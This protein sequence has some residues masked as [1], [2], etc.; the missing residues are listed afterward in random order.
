MEKSPVRKRNTRGEGDRLRRELVSA[1]RALLEETG[2]ED[3]VTLR[4]VAR[5]AGVTAPSIYAHFGDAGAILL[6]VVQE[7]FGELAGALR[8]AGSGAATAAERLD[9]LCA[10]YVQF[11]A[12]SP[13]RY[14]IMFGRHGS[15]RTGAVAAPRPLHELAG[16]EAIGML[17]EALS[18]CA[19][20]GSS[21]SADPRADA[22]AL[23]TGLHG[24]A[25][26]RNALPAFPWPEGL[27]PAMVGR[28]A[29]LRGPAG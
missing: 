14:R 7:A 17:I 21:A 24:Y 1:A 3:A 27:L 22:V 15:A 16:A 26:A 10:A 23:W 28:L 13:H 4:A 19:A 2:N 11:A 29:V 9:A 6:E 5:R 18:D 20:D 12:G 8:A 25:S